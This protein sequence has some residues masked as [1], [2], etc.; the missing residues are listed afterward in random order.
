M[1][2]ENTSQDSLDVSA[3]AVFYEDETI[4]LGDGLDSLSGL[5]GG[6]SWSVTLESLITP[7]ERAERVSD[8]A[9]YANVL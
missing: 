2:I 6:K 1:T 8:Y 4:A 5:A 9:L 3:F 7:E